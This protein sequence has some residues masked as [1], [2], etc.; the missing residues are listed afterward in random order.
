MAWCGF[1]TA[2][3]NPLFNRPFRHYAPMASRLA[4][5]GVLAVVMQYTLY[6]RALVPELI[7]EVSEALTWTLDNVEELGG[8]SR[9]VGCHPPTQSANHGG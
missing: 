2:V 7:S 8:D 4:Q 1:Q 3:N 9:K 6:P 5:A